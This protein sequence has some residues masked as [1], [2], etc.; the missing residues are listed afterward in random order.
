MSWLDQVENNL[1]LEEV[2]KEILTPREA[3][4]LILHRGL[5]G[6]PVCT[7]AELAFIFGISKQRAQQIEA[8]AV[9]KLKTYC[10]NKDVI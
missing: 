7:F 3:I 6:A 10:K 2:I 8:R 9:K 5:F 1:W 4:I